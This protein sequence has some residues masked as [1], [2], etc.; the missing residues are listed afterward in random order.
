MNCKVECSPKF[1]PWNFGKGMEGDVVEA[2]CQII[3]EI[4]HQSAIIRDNDL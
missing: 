2:N 1:R 4:L 3:E